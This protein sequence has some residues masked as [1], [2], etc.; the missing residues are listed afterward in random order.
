MRAGVDAGVAE[1]EVAVHEPA[2]N[3]LSEVDREVVKAMAE[4]IRESKTGDI[5][6]RMGK[7]PTYVSQYRSRLQVAGIIEPSRYGYV[8]FTIPYM[9]EFVKKNAD[10]I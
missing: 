3:D 1:F 2:L 5:A 9:R 7:S 10:R 4:D 8:R 6:D